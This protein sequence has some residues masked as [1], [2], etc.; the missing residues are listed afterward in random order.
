MID[1]RKSAC[2]FW[3]L[4]H[5]VLK[6]PY[7]RFTIRISGSY[8]IGRRYMHDNILYRSS[9]RTTFLLMG[10]PLSSSSLAVQHREQLPL[11]FLVRHSAVVGY[12]ERLCITNA[13]GGLLAIMRFK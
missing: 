1:Q 10:Q 9:F 13:R 4:P 8:S 11:L 12:L 3:R 2:I 7:H 6:L 5:T